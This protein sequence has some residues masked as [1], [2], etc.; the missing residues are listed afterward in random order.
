VKDDGHGHLVGAVGAP[1]AGVT[2]TIDYATRRLSLRLAAPASEAPKVA[3]DVLIEGAVEP[4]LGLKEQFEP[5]PPA[6]PIRWNAGE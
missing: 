2:N 5:D 4:R 6:R 3:Y 1:G